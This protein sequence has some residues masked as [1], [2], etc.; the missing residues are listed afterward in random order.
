MI[1]TTISPALT[2][3]FMQA[4]LTSW[5]FQFWRREAFEPVKFLRLELLCVN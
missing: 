3:F 1:S 5:W 2:S 4:E